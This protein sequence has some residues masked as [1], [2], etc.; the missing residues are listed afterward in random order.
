MKVLVPGYAYELANF[1]KKN[2]AGQKLQFIDLQ[3]EEGTPYLIAKT[4][5]ATNQEVLRALIHSVNHNISINPTE[6]DYIQALIKLEEALMWL[7]KR[8]AEIQRRYDE[9]EN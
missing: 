1:D 7:N 9:G 8:R 5:G 4:D 6:M 3:I 2:E